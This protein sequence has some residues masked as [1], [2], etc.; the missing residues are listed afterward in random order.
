MDPLLIF[1]SCVGSY[2]IGYAFG[3]AAA[4]LWSRH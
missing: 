4:W 1:L 3:L 2:L